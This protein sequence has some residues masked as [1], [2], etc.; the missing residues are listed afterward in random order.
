MTPLTATAKATR[1]RGHKFSQVELRC[2]QCCYGDGG[3]NC[4][5]DVEVVSLRSGLKELWV[6]SRPVSG[7]SPTEEVLEA[8]GLEARTQVDMCVNGRGERRG[9][10]AGSYDPDF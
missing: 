8:A 1:R 9:R 4:I 5:T 10:K 7:E 6:F 3:T 2:F